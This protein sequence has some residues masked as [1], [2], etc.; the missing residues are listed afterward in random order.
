[1]K[2]YQCMFNYTGVP[3]TRDSPHETRTA[4]VMQTRCNI[5]VHHY[6]LDN[7]GKAIEIPQFL[8]AIKGESPDI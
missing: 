8:N 6:K 1:M 7:K 5:A 3:T 2:L 4:N